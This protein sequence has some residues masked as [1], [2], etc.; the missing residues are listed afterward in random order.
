M[1]AKY[2]DD[3]D[4]Y[5][6][7]LEA[8]SLSK[9]EALRDSEKQYRIIEWSERECDEADNLVRYGKEHILRLQRMIEAHIKAAQEEQK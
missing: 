1:W 3:Y 7:Q 5:C 9:D 8:S 4:A 6:T 2:C